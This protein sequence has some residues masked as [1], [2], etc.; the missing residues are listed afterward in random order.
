MAFTEAVI[1]Q[2]RGMKIGSQLTTIHNKAGNGHSAFNTTFVTTIQGNASFV[3]GV[4]ITMGQCSYY[5]RPCDFSKMLAMGQMKQFVENAAH[6]IFLD[7]TITLMDTAPKENLTE[8]V[9]PPTKTAGTTKSQRK[10]AT[11]PVVQRKRKPKKMN[12]TPLTIEST[13]IF[14][15]EG[16]PPITPPPTDGSQNVQTTPEMI[17]K[18]AQTATQIPS[19]EE[20]EAMM[21][22]NGQ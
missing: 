18:N 16:L 22:I 20:I 1:D 10:F 5:L 21:Q 4:V 14:H 19:M 6:P 2:T 12:L 13:G 8:S 17:A 3:E 7:N 11:K 9:T 15:K